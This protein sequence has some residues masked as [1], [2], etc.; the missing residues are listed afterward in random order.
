MSERLGNRVFEGVSGIKRIK[1]II[2]Y[3]FVYK[4]IKLICYKI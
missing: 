4:N 3:H 1:E 2:I